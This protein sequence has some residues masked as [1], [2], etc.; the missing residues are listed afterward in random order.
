MSIFLITG[1]VIL[2]IVYVLYV[3]QRKRVRPYLLGLVLLNIVALITPIVGCAVNLSPTSLGT[4]DWKVV[5]FQYDECR[6]NYDMHHTL[7]L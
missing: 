4:F 1:T 5:S 2:G 6:F 3:G 7:G